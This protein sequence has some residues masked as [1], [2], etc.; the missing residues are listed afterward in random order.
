VTIFIIPY[1]PGRPGRN[2]DDSPL[3]STK[4]ENEQELYLLSTKRLRGV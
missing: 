1:I 3:S 2:A 4:V